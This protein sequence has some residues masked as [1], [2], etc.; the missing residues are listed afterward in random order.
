MR[1]LIILAFLLTTQ[2]ISA[3]NYL[4]S[5]D[6]DK[7]TKKCLKSANKAFKSKKYDKAVKHFEKALKKYDKLIDP[8]IKLGIIYKA[9]NEN[10][11]A[12]VYFEKAIELDPYYEPKV[13]FTL[14]KMHEE[15]GKPD[16]ALVHLKAYRKT[17]T[18]GTP[19]A[20]EI[21]QELEIIHFRDSLVQHPVP[22]ATTPL[23]D[24]I[25]TEES[26]YLPVLSSDGKSL[27]FT[28]V[29]QGQEDFYISHLADSIFTKA[30]PIVSLN[31]VNNEGAHC[32]SSD[33][34]LIIFT[35]C[36]RR[37]GLRGSCD[38][39][40]A[41]KRNGTWTTPKNLGTTV[42][43]EAWD[44]QPSLTAD[45]KTLYFSSRRSQGVGGADIYYSTL[46]N[47]R[48]SKPRLLPGAINSKGD[49]ESPYIHA[50][51]KTL[52]FRSNGHRG[53][54]SFD[55][56]FSRLGKD[57]WSKP[58]NMGYPI[59][60]SADEGALT[61][62]TDGLTA[63]YTSDVNDRHDNTSRVLKT[64]GNFDLF[65][66]ELPEYA[67]PLPTT[68]VK[69]KVLDANTKEGISAN[70]TLKEIALDSILVDTRSDD[71]GDLITVVTAGYDY[72][73]YVEKEGYTFHSENVTFPE[74]ASELEPIIKTI[75]LIAVK[76]ESTSEIV[77]NKPIVL[78]NI[79]FDTGSA[80][81]LPASQFEI[82]K[83]SKL[84]LENPDLR[85][86]II[87]HTDDVGEASDNLLLSR[88][89]AKSV[90]DALLL[91]GIEKNRISHTGEGENQAIAD[92]STPEGRKLNRRTEFVILR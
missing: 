9:Q 67:R 35:A 58:T 46:F 34:R 33:G 90:M 70:M 61:I 42:N 91:S 89:R 5:E 62:S 20:D 76:K 86:K 3:Q 29:S 18:D 15:K 38:L 64:K 26:E 32:L 88:N 17:L 74:G 13:L 59:N 72:A 65:K 82:S 14:Y 92:N 77:Y 44:S 56:Y 6:V 19:R 66:F 37:D 36:D 63:Y 73:I 4:T 10:N 31:T 12:I 48:W 83:L 52:Y 11:R 45:G 47:K 7:K 50:D 81:L 23:G 1:F 16:E 54:G 71:S 87:G 69:I 79:F 57:G 75:E 24:G 85:I 60:T 8:Y 21:D 28:R 55:I 84:L 78:N 49:D 41:Q 2:S 27:I 68:Y 40:Y 53:M 30:E 39:Y 51:G 22:F 43:S 80:T 25:N